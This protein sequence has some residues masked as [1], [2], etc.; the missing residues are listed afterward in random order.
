MN[1]LEKYQGHFFNWYDTQSMQPLKPLYVSSVDSGNL[2]GH[3]LTLQQGLSTLPD[4]LIMG[5]RLFE[6]I[7]DTLQILIEHSGKSI[8]AGIIQFRNYLNTVI[9]EPPPHLMMLR[10]C[11]DQLSAS[12]AEIESDIS[13]AADEQY[14]NMGE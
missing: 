7:N 4:E 11:L 2:A 1:K 12:S 9:K 8:P 10:K 13:P 5:R 3:L 6:G 14:Q